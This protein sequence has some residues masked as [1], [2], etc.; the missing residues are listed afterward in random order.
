IERLSAHYRH[1]LEQ[2]AQD[3]KQP[4]AA[5]QLLTETEREQMLIEW[6]RSAPLGQVAEC[7]HSLVEAQAAA[8]PD[9]CAVVFEDQSLSYGELNTRANRLARYLR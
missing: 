9:A 7:V 3:A 8:H 4:I 2:I 6:N 5:L 1:L